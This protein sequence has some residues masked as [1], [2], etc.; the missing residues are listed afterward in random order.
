L[1]DL[2]STRYIDKQIYNFVF[3]VKTLY[4]ITMNKLAYN[5]QSLSTDNEPNDIY[6]F[7]G[8]D[9]WGATKKDII[10]GGRGKF[11]YALNKELDKLTTIEPLYYLTFYS[12][13]PNI[14]RKY[15]D[16]IYDY[17]YKSANYSTKESA[18]F[19]IDNLF[20]SALDLNFLFTKMGFVGKIYDDGTKEEI[21]IVIDDMM[22]RIEIDASQ[23]Y[24]YATIH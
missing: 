17:M 8:G 15:N 2:L 23:R 18:D 24:S 5:E 20:V 6:K 4:T 11:R 10:R 1:L 14:K 9:L 16:V 19:E 22:E 12:N 13:Y 21:K 7:V 3:A